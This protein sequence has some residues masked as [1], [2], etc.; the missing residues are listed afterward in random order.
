MCVCV[1]YIY[2]IREQCSLQNITI[3]WFVCSQYGE[4]FASSISWQGSTK[5]CSLVLA[6]KYARY[7][8]SLLKGAHN[9]VWKTVHSVG[10]TYKCLTELL[11][12]HQGGQAG[13]INTG[14]WAQSLRKKCTTSCIKCNQCDQSEKAFMKEGSTCAKP[15]AW[16]IKGLMVSFDLVRPHQKKKRQIRFVDYLLYLTYV[17]FSLYLFQCMR[18]STYFSIKRSIFYSKPIFCLKAEIL[19]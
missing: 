15:Q 18:N 12:A 13:K 8:R 3:I 5:T 4:K 6:H 9:L 2:T 11:A 17:N 16:P 1:I 10:H 7:V 14:V 19:M